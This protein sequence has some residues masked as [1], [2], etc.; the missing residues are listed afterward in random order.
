MSTSSKPALIGVAGS[1]ASGKDT[2]AHHLEKDF[3]FTHVSTGDIVREVAMRERGSIER[4]VLH[5][6]AS[7]HR[8]RDG[9]GAFVDEAL[10]KPRPLVITGIRALGEAKAL[11]AAGGVLVFIDAPVQLRY[12]R[13]KSRQRDAEVELTLDQFKA[14]EEKEWYSGDDDADF[15]LRDIKAMSDI[16]IDNVMSLDEFIALAYRKLSIDSI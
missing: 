1:F 5:E 2:V 3:N 12:E 6:V 7:A 8:K 9:A 14:N 16:V 10:K 11:K 4:P 15:N 13:V